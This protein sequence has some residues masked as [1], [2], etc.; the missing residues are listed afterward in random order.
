MS[1]RAFA[2]GGLAIGL[3]AALSACAPG[4]YPPYSGYYAPPPYARAPSQSTRPQSRREP[5]GASDWINPEP[6]K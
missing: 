4:Y 2:L 3:L 5:Q 1:M 6:A